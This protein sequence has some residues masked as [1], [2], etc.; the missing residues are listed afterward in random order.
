MKACLRSAHAG[1]SCPSSPRWARGARHGAVR[2]RARRP[3]ARRKVKRQRAGRRRRASR[4]RARLPWIVTVV[5]A[6]ACAAAAIVLVTRDEGPLVAGLDDARLA[7][8]VP[9][10]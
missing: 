5:V 9:A 4:V 3:R 1:P 6:A 2:A 10:I 8:D 7:P